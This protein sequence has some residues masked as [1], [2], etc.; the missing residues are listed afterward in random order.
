LQL[1]GR[2]G[3]SGP[4][5]RNP[6]DQELGDTEAAEQQGRIEE[7]AGKRV[8]EEGDG[9]GVAGREPS[10][11]WRVH[12]AQRPGAEVADEEEGDRAGDSRGTNPQS[13]G[14]LIVVRGKQPDRIT[15]AQAPDIDELRQL[16]RLTN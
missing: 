14:L 5:Y 15:T 12:A 7:V 16:A 11:G 6:R 2:S 3:G 8:L 10:P 4:G 1:K 9:G 13:K